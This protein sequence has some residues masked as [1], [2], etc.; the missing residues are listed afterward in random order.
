MRKSDPLSIVFAPS[1]NDALYL[2]K[3]MIGVDDRT[4]TKAQLIAEL[5]ALRTEVAMLKQQVDGMTACEPTRCDYLLQREHLLMSFFNAATQSNVGLFILDT[6][7]RYLQ[8][9]QALADMNG[10][11]IEAHLGQPASDLLPD[12]AH[13]VIPL[14]QSVIQT[15]QPI[16][17][18]EVS[19]F[20]PNQPDTLRHWLASYFPIPAQAGSI[21][22]VGGIVQEI[23]QYKQTIEA[24]RQSETA[25]RTAQRLAHVGSWQWDCATDTI[26]WSEE[27]YRIHGRDPN[28]PPPQGNVIAEH[29]HPDDLAL[30]QQLTDQARAGYPF[31]V[32]LRII[33]PD[34][35]IR[36]IEAR[37]EPGV[38]SEQGEL[39]RLYGTVLDVTERKRVEAALRQSEFALQEAQRL[40]HVGSWHWSWE[41]GTI[42]SEE[43]YRIHGLD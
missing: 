8:I 16:S 11:S 32:D 19:G 30:Y 35:E 26:T 2:V 31:E 14:L 24:L 27:M 40:A 20:V 28:L 37:G 7:L 43:I 12:L 3:E 5:E 10:N 25:L 38:F 6:N 33:R 13:T 4:K 18:L 21:I 9:N 29:I 41:T 39:L 15:G 36:Y 42:W 17:N 23:S 1:K 22:A 34:G